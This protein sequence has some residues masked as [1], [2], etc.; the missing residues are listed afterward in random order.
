MHLGSLGI[1]T[2]RIPV[3][4]RAR[5]KPGMRLSEKLRPSA[6]NICLEIG[7]HRQGIMHEACFSP[8]YAG[9]PALIVLHQRHRVIGAR[10]SQISLLTPA[11][12]RKEMG[13]PAKGTYSEP[14]TRE[15]ACAGNC[16]QNGNLTD[17]PT[18]KMQLLPLQG[19]QVA[20]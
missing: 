17:V 11:R 8:S 16:L 3:Q 18:P 20:V 7:T 5:E 15:C 14:Q 9:K 13:G 12:I 19:P 1:V 10:R 4:G 6:R 2:C